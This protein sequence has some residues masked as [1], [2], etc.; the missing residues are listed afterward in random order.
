MWDLIS[1]P[2]NVSSIE[3]FSVATTD[4]TSSSLELDINWCPTLVATHGVVG[5]HGGEV[6][7]RGNV[8]EDPMA[9]GLGI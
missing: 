1:S 9:L 3:D 8:E 6:D 4:D 7:S 2:I 5:Q